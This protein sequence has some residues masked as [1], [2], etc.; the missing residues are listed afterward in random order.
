MSSAA[1][2]RFDPGA[3]IA[4]HN[5]QV[6]LPFFIHV[7]MQSRWNKC[8]HAGNSLHLAPRTNASRHIGHSSCLCPAGASTAPGYGKHPRSFSAATASA[9]SS[10][11]RRWRHQ[12]TQKDLRIGDTTTETVTPEIMHRKTVTGFIV[13]ADR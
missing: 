11:P 3:I 8:W 12:R 2:S 5:G 13:V 4:L 10:R 7:P 6:A 9:S 1:D